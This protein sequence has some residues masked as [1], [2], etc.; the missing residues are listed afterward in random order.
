MA[1]S[2]LLESRQREA[3]IAPAMRTT[4]R[5]LG[6]VGDIAGALLDARLGGRSPAKFAERAKWTASRILEGHGVTVSTTGPLPCPPAVIVTNHVSYLDPLVLSSLVPCLSVAKG[7]TR[8]WPLIGPGMAG[9]GVLFVR[10]GDPHSG[11][12]VLR[13]AHR[14]LRSGTAILNFPEGTTSNG[15]T[16]GP[17]HRGAFGLARVAR[18]P[19]VPALVAYDDTR[20][21][22]F[23]GEAFV[24]HYVRLGRIRRLSATVHFGGPITVSPADDPSTVASAARGIIASLPAT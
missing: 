14:A 13:Q 17:F 4:V 22:W 8:S 11:A 23:G 21:H 20:V 7:E 18:V 6:L 1:D 12:L 9:L 3:P 10:R 16:I 2:L 15:W 5:A 19:V 24:P